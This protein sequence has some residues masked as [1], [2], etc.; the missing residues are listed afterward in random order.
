MAADND[1]NIPIICSLRPNHASQRIGGVAYAHID[2]HAVSGQRPPDRLLQD[3]WARRQHANVVGRP[4][5]PV[6]GERAGAD[7]CAWNVFALEQ[8]DGVTEE[9]HWPAALADAIGRRPAR[10][11][12]AISMRAVCSVMPFDAA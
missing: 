3:P 11:R 10:R 9:R 8:G 4:R 2:A 6:D 7:E 1:I 12:R 5:N